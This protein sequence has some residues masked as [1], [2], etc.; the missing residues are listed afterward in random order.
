MKIKNNTMRKLQDVYLTQEQFDKDLE[1]C[2]VI[3]TYPSKK[4]PYYICHHL[5]ASLE[6]RI[7]NVYI[8]QQSNL[9]PVFEQALK[10]FMP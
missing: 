3:I 10:A 4:K 5:S 7:V 1:T 8:K 6:R 9:H 2:L